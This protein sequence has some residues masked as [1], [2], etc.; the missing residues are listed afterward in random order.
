MEIATKNAGEAV[1]LATALQ[2]LSPGPVE[3]GKLPAVR[4]DAVNGVTT[5]LAERCLE[6]NPLEVAIANGIINGSIK[7]V[8]PR[9]PRKPRV[10]VKSKK[11]KAKAK[12]Q[13]AKAKKVVKKAR[14]KR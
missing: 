8:V 6:I 12:K 1:A 3:S 2:R 14:R 5:M 13:K 10:K 9:P 7:T 11:R 4:G